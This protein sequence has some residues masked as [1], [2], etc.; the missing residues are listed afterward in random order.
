MG[1]GAKRWA[2][3]LYN[4]P[5][6]SV[7]DYII[8]NLSSSLDRIGHASG[9]RS[10]YKLKAQV[11][12]NEEALKNGGEFGPITTEWMFA[13]LKARHY[14]PAGKPITRIT[15]QLGNLNGAIWK[16]LGLGIRT[17]EGVWGWLGGKRRELKS[18][19]RIST[20]RE[21]FG[22][23]R[24]SN[25]AIN[26]KLN[27]V[28]SHHCLPIEFINKAASIGSE[29]PRDEFPSELRRIDEFLNTET[30]GQ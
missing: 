21:M 29:V 11:A 28:I 26:R 24:G 27:N 13:T 16:E 1:D 14:E 20:N 9:G 15:N 4:R 5:V 18:S 25:I 10:K 7:I 3:A 12:E 8:V 19:G 30:P 6:K 17:P 23:F 2:K 22:Y